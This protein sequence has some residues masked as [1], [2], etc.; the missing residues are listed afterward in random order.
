MVEFKV[1]GCRRVYLHVAYF[2]IHF[3]SIFCIARFESWFLGS[4]EK[5]TEEFPHEVVSQE[6]F[7]SLACCFCRFFFVGGKINELCLLRVPSFLDRSPVSAPF[8]FSARLLCIF[9]IMLFSEKRG[10][11]EWEF[12]FLDAFLYTA[13]S[14]TMY[15]SMVC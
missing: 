13:H 10:V 7:F 5:K 4:L 12:A 3:G 15:N 14:A 9:H 1:T 6:F 2:A 8:F 11:G